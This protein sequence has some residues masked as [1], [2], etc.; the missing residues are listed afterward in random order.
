[1]L[2]FTDGGR[3]RT[4]REYR[5]LFARAGLVLKQIYETDTPMSILEGQRTDHST[6]AAA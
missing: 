6:A 5:E 4:R 1:M 3:E 2:V